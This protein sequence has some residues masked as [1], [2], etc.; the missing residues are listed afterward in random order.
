[1]LPASQKYLCWAWRVPPHRV[2]VIA[3]DGSCS[4]VELSFKAGCYST[5]AVDCHM[6]GAGLQAAS[7]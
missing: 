5:Y 4:S 7:G 6:V 2:G 1:M 3:L